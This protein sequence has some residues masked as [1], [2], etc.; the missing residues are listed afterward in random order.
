[1]LFELQENPLWRYFD[2]EPEIKRL[3][4]PFDSNSLVDRFISL[5]GQTYIEAEASHRSKDPKL[6]SLFETSK[7]E[8]VEY[9]L[10]KII[11]VKLGCYAR[12]INN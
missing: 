2:V 3:D 10:R 6:Q 5:D 1:M 8:Y 12:Y 9:V 7:D 11:S 4:V